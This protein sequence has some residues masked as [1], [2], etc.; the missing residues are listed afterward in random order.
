ML[1]LYLGMWGF[2]DRQLTLRKLLHDALTNGASA[3]SLKRRWRC[4]Q[5]SV[6]R[7]CSLVLSEDEWNGDWSY[8]LQLSSAEPRSVGTKQQRGSIPRLDQSSFC[9]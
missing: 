2:H 1:M 5:S 6:Y 3:E 9:K 8:L 4:Q 7:Q